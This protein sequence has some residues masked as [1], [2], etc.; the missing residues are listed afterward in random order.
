MAVATPTVSVPTWPVHTFVSEPDIQFAK[1]AYNKTAETAPGYLFLTPGQANTGVIMTDEGDLVWSAPYDQFE[2][3]SFINMAK[4]TLNN[5]PVL[6]YNDIV[7]GSITEVVA[8]GTVVI[9]DES[10]EVKHNVTLAD[11]DLVTQYPG[12]H[13]SVINDHEAYITLDNTLLVV[14][15]NATPWDLTPVGGPKDGWLRDCLFYELDINTNEILYRWRASDEIPPTKSHAALGGPG[16][17][18]GNGTSKE[19][20]WDAY[21]INSL[22]DY[23]GG[24]LVSIRNTFM[25]VWVDKKTAKIGW[26]LEGSSGGNFTLDSKNLFSWQHDVRIEKD[27]P[28]GRPVLHMFNN[29]NGQPGE[30]NPSNGLVLDLDLEKKTAK[31]L[32]TYTDPKHPML[33]WNSGSFQWVKDKTHALIGYGSES[34]VH[35]FDASGK[36]IYEMVYG[37]P[38]LGYSYRV[39]RDSW[40]GK[41]KTQPKVKV[42]KQDDGKLYA[43]MSWNGA[44]DVHHWDVF[45]GAGNQTHSLKKAMTVKKTGFETNVTLAADTKFVQV[46][47]HTKANCKNAKRSSVVAVTACK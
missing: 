21:H 41:P 17:V 43:Y 31:T 34:R 23:E 5:E 40:T 12:E 10:Y 32:K 4:Q 37:L 9:I 35:E 20:S 24:F 28:A 1:I 33:A 7:S 39:L 25:A 38:Y 46:A 44:T 45:A 26:T 14:A 22:Q 42:C 18:Y 6:V 29:R 13:A 27:S 19:Q 30:K 36:M 16:G 3:F 2:A 11:P 15:Y 8:Y 47:A